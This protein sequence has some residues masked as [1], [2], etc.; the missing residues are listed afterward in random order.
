LCGSNPREIAIAARQ[1]YTNSSHLE[2][3]ELM[4]KRVYI[5]GPYG[6]TESGTKYLEGEVLPILLQAGFHPLNPWVDGA[7]ILKPVVS[8]D[9]ASIEEVRSACSQVGS[10]NAEMIRH[11]SAVMALLDGLEC[12]SGTCAEIGFA[13][14]LGLPVVG[15]RTDSRSAGDV[16][17]I[18]INL[19]VLYF[20]EVNGGTLAPTLAAAVE[21]LTRCLA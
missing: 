1:S 19:Q 18:P 8:R 3:S 12:D 4:N 14:A 10:R 16:P 21:V 2:Y 13:A 17:E 5:A 7:A 15:L 20:L 9:D 6:F 11:S